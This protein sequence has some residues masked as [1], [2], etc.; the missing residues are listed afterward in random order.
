MSRHGELAMEKEENAAPSG[1]DAPKTV[2]TKKL[3]DVL[4]ELKQ[5][6]RDGKLAD[7]QRMYGVALGICI[8]LMELNKLE[9]KDPYCYAGALGMRQLLIDEFGQKSLKEIRDYAFPEF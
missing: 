9:G 4:H 8:A 1:C 2:V 7:V 6:A 3:F 5:R